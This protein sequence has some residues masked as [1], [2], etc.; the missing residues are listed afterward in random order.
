[1]VQSVGSRARLPGFE[2]QFH[3][4]LAVTLD[5]LLLS[6]VAQ[7]PHLLKGNNYTSIYCLY[8]DS[9]Y[10]LAAVIFMIASI[11]K[12][13]SSGHLLHEVVLELPTLR[14]T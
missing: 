6:S 14:R 11:L 9:T 7:F 13:L 4:L 3:F 10:I 12:S 1:M 8:V 2:S 5:K